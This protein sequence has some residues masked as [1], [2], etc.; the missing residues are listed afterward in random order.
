MCGGVVVGNDRDGL[1][2]SD[3]V[4]NDVQD[5]LRFS[6]ARRAL[7]DADFGRKCTFNRQ[8]LTLV[9]TERINDRIRYLGRFYLRL[10]IE[11]ARQHGILADFLDF[12]V[13]RTQNVDAVF[14]H[15]TDCRGSFFEV[16]EDFFIFAV[17]KA[18]LLE[19]DFAAA[20]QLIFCTFAENAVIRAKIQKLIDAMNRL[21]VYGDDKPC[22]IKPLLQRKNFYIAALKA[23]NLM[24]RT[25]IRNLTGSIMKLEIGNR[26]C[27]IC[28]FY[29]DQ[30]FSWI[31]EKLLV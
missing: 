13:L 6:S 22:R 21:A 19:L 20:E 14:R 24:R 3:N 7:D 15:K 28:P 31:H 2:A 16:L 27:L 18:I 12:V 30:I 1:S 23:I 10:R 11:I 17:G 9:Q 29:H 25:E 8:F 4:G 5:G 26:A